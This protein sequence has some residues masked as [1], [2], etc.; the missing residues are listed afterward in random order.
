MVYDVNSCNIRQLPSL[1]GCVDVDKKGSIDVIELN[2]SRSLLLTSAYSFDEMAI[3]KLSTLDPYC[4]TKVL[5]YFY[6][7]FTIHLLKI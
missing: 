4:V 1:K 7:S 3:Y 6:Y 2:S 5:L